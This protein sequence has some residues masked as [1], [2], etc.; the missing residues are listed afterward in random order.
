MT[1]VDALNLKVGS[2]VYYGEFF[3]PIVVLNIQNNGGGN[4]DLFT[5][6]GHFSPAQVTDERPKTEKLIEKFLNDPD[7]K[8]HLHYNNELGYNV[9]CWA[10]VLDRKPDF[11][12]DAFNTR[13]EAVEYVEKYYLT[14]EKFPDL[15]YAGEWLINETMAWWGLYRLQHGFPVEQKG[16]LAEA[17]TIFLISANGWSDPLVD[18]TVQHLKAALEL[19]TGLKG[20]NVRQAVNVKGEVRTEGEFEYLYLPNETGAPEEHGLRSNKAEPW[21]INTIPWEGPECGWVCFETESPG[22]Y[23]KIPFGFNG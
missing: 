12:L 18:K 10:V 4:V 20:L 1:Y 16:P 19:K 11:W 5:T 9:W 23:I 14:M 3:E 13:E 2:I 8:V 21:F 15:D 17:G 6:E 7:T 22:Q